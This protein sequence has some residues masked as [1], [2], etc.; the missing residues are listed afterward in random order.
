MY[1]THRWQTNHTQQVVENGH[2]QACEGINLM[3]PSNS[4]LTC[5]GKPKE[6]FCNM[7]LIN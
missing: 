2:I 4:K 1:E 5:A 6:F 7:T 3:S